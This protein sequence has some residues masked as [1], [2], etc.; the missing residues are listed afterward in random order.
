[1]EVLAAA[2]AVTVNHLMVLVAPW[3]ARRKLELELQVALEAPVA[4]QVC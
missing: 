1:M 3:A 4:D 2:V